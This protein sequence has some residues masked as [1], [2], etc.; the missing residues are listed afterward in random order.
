VKL[1]GYKRGDVVSPFVLREH[2]S[3]AFTAISRVNT[4]LSGDEAQRQGFLRRVHA[5]FHRRLKRAGIHVEQATR[6]G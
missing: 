5:D 6:G 1:T 3:R 4:N 2:Y